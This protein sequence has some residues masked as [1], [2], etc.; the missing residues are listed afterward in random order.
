MQCIFAALSP[1]RQVSALD[2][3]GHSCMQAVLQEQR[4]LLVSHHLASF[5]NADASRHTALAEVCTCWW[6]RFTPMT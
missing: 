4:E 2:T 1:S 5:R 6:V 3:T